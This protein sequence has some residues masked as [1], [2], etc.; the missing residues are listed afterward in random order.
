MNSYEAALQI[1][2]KS[3]R[4]ETGV[5]TDCLYRSTIYIFSYNNMSIS[6]YRDG[7]SITVK[8]NHVENRKTFKKKH[9][10]LYRIAEK[11]YKYLIKK[12]YS[13]FLEELSKKLQ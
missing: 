6:L 7:Y 9:R 2:D 13:S 1:I 3:E 8:E 5:L 10:L 11:K 12:Q 4:V